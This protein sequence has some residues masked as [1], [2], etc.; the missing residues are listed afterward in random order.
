MILSALREMRHVVMVDG[1]FDPI[2][3]GHIAYFEAAA[4][5][6]SP[7]LC[8]VRDDNYVSTKHTPFL[9]EDQRIQVIAAIR[10]IDYCTVGSEPT[11]RAL[12]IIKPQMYV[13]GSDWSLDTLP[14]E[15]LEICEKWG[16]KNVF[17]DTKLDSSTDLLAKFKQGK[18]NEH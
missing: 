17:L 11:S 6:G 14:K 10:H 18:N 1:G 2:H 4:K 7:V 5:L 9:S 12:E 15:E 8:Y 16:I 13:K 3:H